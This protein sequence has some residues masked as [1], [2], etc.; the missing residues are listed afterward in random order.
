M[1]CLGV[2]ENV[3]GPMRTGFALRVICGILG[4]LLLMGRMDVVTRLDGWVLLPVVWR[5]SP[6][7]LPSVDVCLLKKL[8]R[9]E[10]MGI[11]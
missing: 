6:L 9:K 10:R 5:G 3:V 2:A 11:M 4:V 8:N 1:R 7:C